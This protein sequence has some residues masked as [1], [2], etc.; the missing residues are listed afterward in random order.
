MPILEE[1]HPSDVELVQQLL[2]AQEK[3]V[4]VS[5]KLKE[6]GRKPAELIA[7]YLY[8][9]NPK[10]SELLTELKEYIKNNNPS[11]V[12]RQRAGE[13]MEQIAFLALCGLEG[14]NAVKNFQSVSAQYDLLVSG[15]EVSWRRLFS[16]LGVTNLPK[17]ILVEAK[18]Y[19]KPIEDKHFSRLCN[20]I[21][22]NLENSVGIGIFF[23][24]K[25][26]TGFPQR[27]GRRRRA[28]SDCWFRQVLFYAKT[29]KPIVVLDAE[30]IFSLDNNGSLIKLLER[31]I[32][33]IEELTGLPVEVEEWEVIDI[34]SHLGILRES[35]DLGLI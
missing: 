30:D 4:D 8:R 14:V 6:R 1:K 32:S 5:G 35:I 18:A 25:G 31:K 17:G 22:L 13:L 24:I 10:I 34:P 15:E 3:W 7:S 27:D 29:N 11:K 23:T 33:D 9:P 21:Q 26:A 12:E 20:L 2:E 16:I 28:I 19:A